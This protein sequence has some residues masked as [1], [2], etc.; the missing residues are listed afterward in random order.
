M[1]I[2][3]AFIVDLPVNSMVIFHYVSLP[4]GKV[5][6]YICFWENGDISEIFEEVAEW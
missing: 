5:Y 4:E 6:I 1:V 3:I 2:E